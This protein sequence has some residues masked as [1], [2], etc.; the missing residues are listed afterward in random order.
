MEKAIID[1]REQ[2]GV[3]NAKE[4]LKTLKPFRKSLPNAGKEQLELIQ[5][6]ADA[7]LENGQVEKAYSLIQKSCQLDADGKIGGCAKF[8]S[9]GQITG[10]P[11]GISIIMKGIE[12]ISAIA[13]DSLS[14]EQ[15]AMMVNGLLAMI[16]IWM[17][18][19]CMEQEA[20]TECEELI[21]KAM[22][23][24]EG[25]SSEVWSVLGSIKISQQKFS[26]A[27]EAFTKAWEFFQLKKS[28]IEEQLT[29]GAVSSHA[30]YLEL[31]Q[32]AISLAKMCIE[33]G[34]YEISLQ[35]VGTIK[36]IDEDNLEN[37]YLEGFT[38]YLVAKLE[39]FRQQNPSLQL[40]PDNIY[41][42]NTHLQELPLDIGNELLKETIY[43]ARA[44]LSFACK[45]SENAD[46]DDEVAKEITEGAAALLNELGGALDVTELMKLKGGE[47]VTAVDEI[48]IDD[49]E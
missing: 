13:G 49:L 4:A 6:F 43:D 2:L 26:E 47:E 20:E 37:Y 31:L 35:I 39:Q 44:A 27:S 17:T 8:F 40:S 41:E 1:A 3:Q 22:E 28:Y 46:P 38:H 30:E 10:G 34:L 25:K 48:D 36:E 24:S 32:P 45:I 29:Q 11:D 14:Q 19:L 18:D 16:E 7:Y 5:V 33:M 15:A 23:I 12:N 9:L 42:F 21:S